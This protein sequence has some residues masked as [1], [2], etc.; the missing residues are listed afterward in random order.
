MRAFWVAVQFLTRL[1][2]PH[3]LD[4]T[5]RDLG[6][7]LF[8]Y[9]LVGLLLGSLLVLLAWVLGRSPIELMAA[10]LVAFWV[11]LTGALHL[12]GLADSADAWVGGLGDRTR[13]LAIMQDAC[14]GPMGVTA[15]V[16]VLLL[17]FAAVSALLRFEAWGVL[18]CVPMLARCSVPLLLITT[19]CARATGLAA[20]LASERPTR[21]LPLLLLGVALAVVVVL[22]V[23]GLW[24]LVAG[25]GLIWW[26][27]RAL[28]ARLGGITG[29]SLGAVIE[30]TE[31]VLLV[32]AALLLN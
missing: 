22:G 13:T 17:K 26:A 14:C 5:P 3:L 20:S 8:A 28:L 18:V 6:R 24:L 21:G 2:T 32:T 10:L 27:R 4:L 25:L 11:V 30:L 19:P 9:P 16:L 31:V 15:I 23:L 7:S 12:D 1:P 29:D